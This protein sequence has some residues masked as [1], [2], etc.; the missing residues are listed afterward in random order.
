VEQVQDEIDIEKLK[1]MKGSDGID[2]TV[3]EQYLSD[4]QFQTAFGMGK[5]EFRKMPLW[6]RQN[7]K[8]KAGLF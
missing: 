7:Q 4:E 2:P 5:D 3:K 6:K 1:F 8:K